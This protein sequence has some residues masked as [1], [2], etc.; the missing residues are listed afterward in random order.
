MKEVA[1]E[2]ALTFIEPGPVTLVT[3]FDGKRNNVMTISWTMAID[4]DGHIVITTGSWNRSFGTMMR[5]G[6][7]VVCIPPAG[8]AEM[9]VGVGM[10]SGAD[11]DKFARFGLTALPAKTVNAPLIA[12]CLACLECKVEDYVEEYGFVVLKVTRVC[13][14]EDAP[15][16]RLLHAVGDGTFVADGEKYNLREQMKAK[17]PPN[18]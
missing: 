7:C 3:T 12:E 15:D 5:T 8:M 9:V 16:K 6:E 17:L 10:V 14:N 11:E 2:R 18:L 13:V 1:T 4:F